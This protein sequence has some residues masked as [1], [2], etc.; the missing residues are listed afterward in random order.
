MFSSQVSSLLKVRTSRFSGF[1]SVCLSPD[2]QMEGAANSFKR[3]RKSWIP[4]S[5]ICLRRLL[6][7]SIHNYQRHM[8]FSIRAEIMNGGQIGFRGLLGFLHDVLCRGT[9]HSQPCRTSPALH[10]WQLCR[11]HC[12]FAGTA[13]RSQRSES[14]ARISFGIRQPGFRPCVSPSGILC[15]TRGHPPFDRRRPHE[16]LRHEPAAKDCGRTHA[17][18]NREFRRMVHLAIIAHGHCCNG[19]STGSPNHRRSC[20]APYPNLSALNPAPRTPCAKRLRVG[21]AE[22]D[23]VHFTPLIAGRVTLGC[24]MLLTCLYRSSHSPHD[25]L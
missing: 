1:P 21:P 17:S 5:E 9:E 8:Q 3:Y 2:C 7:H 24:T 25:S 18:R 20:F 19:A 6:S 23:L 11:S 4:Q 10:D 22:L 13:A 16:K 14:V 12:D 15:T